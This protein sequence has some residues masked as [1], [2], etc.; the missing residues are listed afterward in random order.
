MGLPAGRKDKQM[1][2]ARLF[3]I[4]L[5]VLSI[6]LPAACFAP[7]PLLS[8]T[9][10]QNT[11]PLNNN[12]P[13]ANRVGAQNR[14][15]V[16]SQNRPPLG[17]NRPAPARPGQM[18][19]PQTGGPPQNG[20][21]PPRPPQGGGG[22]P[23]AQHRPPQRPRPHYTFGDGGNGWRLRHYFNNDMARLNRRRRRVFLAGG[24]F[25]HQYLG[26]IQPIPP[27]IISYLPPVP[28]G[29]AVGYYDGYAMVY[30]P[31]TYLIASVL[32]LFRY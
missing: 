13:T 4:C 1:R 31:T 25:P 19:P 32:D 7:A 11:Q 17:N 27:D 26:A 8:A 23:P 16:P 28:P 9:S 12:R 30:D 3:Q 15:T 6:V 29:Y 2:A 10:P 18:R 24:Y 22:R 5:R 14:G 20:G 21:R